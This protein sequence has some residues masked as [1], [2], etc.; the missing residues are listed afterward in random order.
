M[1]RWVSACMYGFLN[2]WVTAT[3]RGERW[4]VEGMTNEL[5]KSYFV[6]VQVDES[7]VV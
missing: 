4:G 1:G 5:H 3:E 2:Q 6:R 7:V